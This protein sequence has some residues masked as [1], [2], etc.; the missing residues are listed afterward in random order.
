MF[1]IAVQFGI[2]SAIGVIGTIAHYV[3]LLMLVELFS[4]NASLVFLG[5]RH[6]RRSD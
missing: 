3:V 5:W 4:R 6:R 1:K 2:F